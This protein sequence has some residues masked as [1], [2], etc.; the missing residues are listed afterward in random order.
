[1]LEDI[2]K[3]GKDVYYKGWIAEAIVKKVS[4]NGG[5]LTMG[6]MASHITTFPK[7]ISTE[8]NGINV[9]QVPPNG[10]V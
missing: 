1:M 6:D 7:A 2:G 5:Y 8:Y 3:E 10:Q 9:W 4:E